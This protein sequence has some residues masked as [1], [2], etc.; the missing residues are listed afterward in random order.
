MVDQ[1]A[2]LR[3]IDCLTMIEQRLPAL[4]G[5]SRRVAEAIVRDPW[6]ILGMT[7]YDVAAASGVSLPSVT[8]FCRAVGYPGFRELVQGIA[9]SLGRIESKDLETLEAPASE[10][11]LGVLANAIVK[12]QIDA[13]QTTVKTLDFDAIERATEAIAAARRVTVIGHG[14]AYVPALGI[15]V[16]L[17]WAGVAAVAATPDLF[18]NHVI[19]VDTDDVVIGVS[20]QGRT[21]DTIDML[22]LARTFGATT[23]AVSAVPQSPLAS[24]TDIAIAVLTPEVAR[25]GTFLIAFDTLMVLADILAAAVAERKWGGAPPHRAEVVEW[26]ETN[27]RVG[28]LPHPRSPSRTRGPRGV[29]PVVADGSNGH[30]EG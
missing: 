17:N 16:K 27:L 8:R 7:I 22:Q 11:G 23:I 28:P 13:L 25:A 5:A 26:I 19:A 6:A 9:Q 3:S 21:H 20:H 2:R 1:A 30:A 29:Q 14:G 12:R 10:N 18:S 24:A 15:S 4:T